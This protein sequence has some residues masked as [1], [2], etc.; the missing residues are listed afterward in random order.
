M[1]I[2]K[3]VYILINKYRTFIIVTAKQ[4]CLHTNTSVLWLSCT[5]T[6]LFFIDLHRKHLLDPLIFM[7]MVYYMYSVSSQNLIVDS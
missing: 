5:C 6:K 1:P 3:N 4:Y 7:Y 2:N